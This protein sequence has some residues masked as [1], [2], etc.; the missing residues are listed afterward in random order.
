MEPLANAQ[1]MIFTVKSFSLKGQ[2]ISFLQYD[3]KIE[4]FTTA[5]AICAI[6]R[7]NGVVSCVGDIPATAEV[8]DEKVFIFASSAD[9]PFGRGKLKYKATI[10]CP[11]EHYSSGVQV[12]KTING[13][14]EYEISSQGEPSFA[15]EIQVVVTFPL[16]EASA[17]AIAQA[18]AVESSRATD[19]E[20]G[21]DNRIDTVAATIPSVVD[22]VTS[23]AEDD[24]LSAKQGTLLND[25][26]NN[27]QSRG[28]FLALWDCTTGLPL[29]NPSGYPYEYHTGDYFRI[30]NVAS[31]EGEKNYM[32]EGTSYEGEASTT[33]YS[34]EVA[35]GDCWFYDGASWYLEVNH[36]GG[37]VQDV[38]VDG[39]SVVS[40]GVA[41][42]AKEVFVAT[43][44]VTTYQ[45]VVNALAANKVVICC[46]NN[47]FYYA[48][49]HTVGVSILFG[50]TYADWS[51]VI[52]VYNN[53]S[54]GNTIYR[55]ELSSNKV[56]ALSA[57]STDAQYP[58][59]KCVY[60]R[61]G[62]TSI[63]VVSALPTNPDADTLYF[64]MED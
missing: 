29:S 51:R 63:A 25:R 43:Y 21:L 6:Q 7:V 22:N 52:Y 24:A 5:D 2:M 20:A 27:L 17:Q 8:T 18:V 62:G 1:D 30:S 26:I 33:E 4:L 40:G 16:S 12:L 31:E 56:T 3:W 19:A 9:H 50:A 39:V 59:A 46:F 60:D 58:S 42:I 34:G 48:Q 41:N 38:Q 54:W 35:S 44:G 23:T 61:M 10:F 14:T 55:P 64:V 13:Y 28:R 15:G 57:S 49:S 47:I 37:M 32:P 53:N 36:I 45:E 11:S